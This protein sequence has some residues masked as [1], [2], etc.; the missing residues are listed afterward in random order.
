MILSCPLIWTRSVLWQHI[1][2]RFVCV[3][4]SLYRKAQG[5]HCTRLPDDGSSVIRNML[6][7]FSIF[8]N[9]NCI[10][11][12]HIVDQLD[13]IVFKNEIN[14]I[15]LLHLSPR[16]LQVIYTMNTYVHCI[17]CSYYILI[18]NF[19]YTLFLMS[20]NTDTF[21]ENFTH[22]WHQQIC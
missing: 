5:K 14:C 9:F 17:Y 21:F 18:I 12:L 19:S 15:I 10:Y 20:S 11:K 6:E 13:N 16:I 22:P 2:T 7:H 8:C 4:S 3:C 1:V